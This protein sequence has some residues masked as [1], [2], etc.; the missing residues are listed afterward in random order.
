MAR[1]K[2]STNKKT[3]KTQEVPTYDSFIKGLA[4]PGKVNLEPCG[5]KFNNEDMNLLV[6]KLNEVIEKVNNG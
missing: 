6:D 1:T 3:S 4:K 2:G 5:L